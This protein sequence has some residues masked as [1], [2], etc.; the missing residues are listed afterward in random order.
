MTLDCS[1]PNLKSLAN[2]FHKF[3]LQIDFGRDTMN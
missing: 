3:Y 2:A 1:L